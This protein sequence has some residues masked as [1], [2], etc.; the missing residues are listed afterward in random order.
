MTPEKRVELALSL[1]DDVG[2]ISADAKARAAVNPLLIRL[3]VWIGL[4]FGT[5][6]KGSKRNVQKLLSGQMTFGN[7]PLPVLLF[8]KDHVAGG[9]HGGAD[10]HRPTENKETNTDAGFF[11]VAG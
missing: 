5:V 1:L 11:S 4:R 2:R 3:G 9:P 8:G 10:S 6:V 7:T